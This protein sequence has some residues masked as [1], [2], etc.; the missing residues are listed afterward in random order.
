MAKIDVK[1]PATQ[2]QFYNDATKPQNKIV[3]DRIYAQYKDPIDRCEELTHVPKEIIISFIFIESGGNPTVVSGAGAVGLMQLIPSSASD[4]LVIENTKGRLSQPEKDILA[5]NIGSRFTDGILKMRYL[6]DQVSVAG[7]KSATWIT[8]ADLMKPSLNMLIGCLYLGILIDESTKD[9][10][11]DLHKV[12]IR[13]NKG[14]FADNRGAKIPATVEDA[15]A[16]TNTESKNYILKLMGK[17]GTLDTIS[18]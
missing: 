3:L 1:I 10:K 6:G 8:K 5:A 18:V 7:V 4:I 13:Y 15:L 11:V 16:Q 2:I 9:N 14:Y 17:N 12:V